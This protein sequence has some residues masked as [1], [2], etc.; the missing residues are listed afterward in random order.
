LQH[1]HISER[2]IRNDEHTSTAGEIVSKRTLVVYEEE[3][4]Q[5]GPRWTLSIDR[6]AEG[7][8]GLIFT[9]QYAACNETKAQMETTVVVKNGRALLAPVVDWLN[10]QK[11]LETR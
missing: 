7:A 8:P 2:N 1:K 4:K 5:D 3:R 9:I 10:S 6:A 11:V